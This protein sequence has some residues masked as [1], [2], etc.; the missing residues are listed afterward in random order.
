MCANEMNMYC[1]LNRKLIMLHAIKP[2][3]SLMQHCITVT[4]TYMYCTQQLLSFFC[5]G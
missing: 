4:A 3:D 5:P 1:R 2:E